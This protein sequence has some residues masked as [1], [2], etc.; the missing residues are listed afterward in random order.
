GEGNA[1][2]F[3]AILLAIFAAF[4]VG[5]LAG[6]LFS[7]I[8]VTLRANQNVTGLA[9][10][11]FGTGV[12]KFVGEIMRNKLGGYVSVSNHLKESFDLR[13]MPDFLKK[14]PIIGKIVFNQTHFFYLAI[15]LAVLMHLF[16]TR[17][18]TGLYLR[19]VGESP[20]TA[21]AAGLNITKYKYL[22]T[23]I[24][25]GISAIG[26]MVYTMTTAG[27][28]WIE[29]SLSG[30]GWLAVA[31][32]IFCTWRPLNAIWASILFGSLMIM[33]LRIIIPGFPTEIYKII[34]YIVTVIVLVVT[35]MRNNK[36]KQP[37]TSLGLNYFRE[38]R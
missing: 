31:L 32:V 37:P 10:T 20:V 14:L 24:G 34:P 26:G 13:F 25:G 3:I 16:L 9:M 17:T 21:D 1:N 6:A 27:C 7:F 36:E 5:A 29:A 33:Y 19:A 35:S 11:T 30:V 2:P 23:I 28:V 8:T 22:A 18:K 15:I 4:F 38:E 12:A